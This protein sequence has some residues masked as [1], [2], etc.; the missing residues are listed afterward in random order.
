MEEGADDL[1][2]GRVHTLKEVSSVASLH[3]LRV[4]GK[5]ALAQS[6][7]AV[8]DCTTALPEKLSKRG[9]FRPCLGQ[10]RLL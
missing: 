2:G 5:T 8:L 3:K 10:S 6:D 9:M 4:W 7:M 1:E